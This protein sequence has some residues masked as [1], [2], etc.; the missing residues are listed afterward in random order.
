LAA[1]RP[2]C[3]FVPSCL[4]AFSS[5]SSRSLPAAAGRFVASSLLLAALSPALAQPTPQELTKQVGIDQN[6][7][8]QVPLDLTFRDETGAPVRLG[9]C[10]RGKPVVLSLVYYE[11]PMLCGLIFDGLLKSLR[12][13][14]LDVAEDFDII[15]VSFDPGET[16]QLAAAK[17]E[18]C[19][20]QYGRPGAAAGW[21]F[22]T[23]DEASIRALTDAVGFRYVY[24]PATDQYAHASSL[25]VLTPNGRIARYLY[26]I[27]YQPR[28]LKL[29]LVEAADGRI[30]SPVDQLL[31]LCYHYDPTTG[32][33]GLVVMNSIRIGGF[34]TVASLL[35]FV[36]AMLRRERR[37]ARRERGLQ[38]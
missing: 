8:A 36:V 3:A 20:R 25:M 22:L 38:P 15:T 5:P 19:L 7:D 2:R 1:A 6:L 12:V 29:S 24:D 4:C 35:T 31:L 33:Y 18:N 30:G 11:C 9:D 37:S 17:K 28:D 10:F 34:L 27:E 23:G 21:R 26:G 32:K 16:P 13:L 14:P